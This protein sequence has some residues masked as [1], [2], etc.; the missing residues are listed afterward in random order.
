ML[1]GCSSSIKE[2]AVVIKKD[3]EERGEVQGQGSGKARRNGLIN[4]SLPSR[5]QEQLVRPPSIG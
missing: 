3:Y 5:R 2:V 1:R 4:E